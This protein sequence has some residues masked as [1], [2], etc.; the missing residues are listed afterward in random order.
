MA[1]K[2]LNIK[3]YNSKNLKYFDRLICL[4]ESLGISIS[5]T[6]VSFGEKQ[7]FDLISS[8]FGQITQKEEQ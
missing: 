4:L 8:I 2:T 5:Y 7:A 3:L 6:D 1:E